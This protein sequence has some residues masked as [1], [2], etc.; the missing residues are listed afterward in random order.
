MYSP[1]LVVSNYVHQHNFFYLSGE[2]LMD[3]EL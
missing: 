1:G 3:N 2:V